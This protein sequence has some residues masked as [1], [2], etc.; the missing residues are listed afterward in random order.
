M[1]V[2]KPIIQ[3]SRRGFQKRDHYGIFMTLCIAALAIEENKIVMV[4]DFM[5]SDTEYLPN[6]KEGRA[7][8]VQPLAT[9]NGW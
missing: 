7:L 3:P 8:K 9:E 6:S 2:G 1:N 5:M 4:S